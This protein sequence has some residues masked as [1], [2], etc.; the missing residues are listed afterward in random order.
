M[1]TSADIKKLQ[2]VFPSKKD[3]KDSFKRADRRFDRIE[4]IVVQD[5]ENITALEPRM[6]RMED[7]LHRIVKGIDTL[8][9]EFQELRRE[10]AAMKEQLDRH[11]RWIKQIAQKSGVVLAD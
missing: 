3:I 9:T 4:N 2:S 5:H 11:E 10:Y 6:E 8:V 7:L 1:L